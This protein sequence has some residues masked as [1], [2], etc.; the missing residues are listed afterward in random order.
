MSMPPEITREEAEGILADR[1]SRVTGEAVGALARTVVA[2]Y[3]ELDD[4]RAEHEAA[5]ADVLARDACIA[6][7]RNGWMPVTRTVSGLSMEEVYGFS[8]P[9][10]CM[11]G[12]HGAPITRSV[13]PVPMTDAER[14]VMER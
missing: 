4:L 9:H 1:Y 14:E 8:T 11:R 3:D 2:L 5:K 13:P 12:Y 6:R 10:W 7:L